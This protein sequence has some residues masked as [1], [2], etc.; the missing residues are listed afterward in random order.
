[1]FYKNPNYEGGKKYHQKIDEIEYLD[2]KL[3]KRLN[4]NEIHEDA[5]SQDIVN[6]MKFDEPIEVS[7]F[8]DGEIKIIDGHHRVGAAKRLGLN[9]VKVKVQAVNAK[10]DNINS[11]I[12]ESNRLKSLNNPRWRRLNKK[13]KRLLSWII[14]NGHIYDVHADGSAILYD[15]KKLGLITI[16]PNDTKGSPKYIPTAAGKSFSLMNSQYKNIDSKELNDYVNSEYAD[17]FLPERL[18]QE[19]ELKLAKQ[20]IGPAF[21]DE[22]GKLK[23]KEIWQFRPPNLNNPDNNNKE[24]FMKDALAK[25]PSWAKILQEHPDAYIIRK[26]RRGGYYNDVLVWNDNK[27]NNNPVE[28]DD[29]LD[30]MDMVLKQAHMARNSGDVEEEKYLKNIA[31]DIAQDYE[32]M[33]Q[34]EDNTPIAYRFQQYKNRVDE[35]KY[36]QAMREKEDR[37]RNKNPIP[38]G[39]M[40][41]RAAIGY[42]GSSM[43]P[44]PE[45]PYYK[46]EFNRLLD[47]MNEA[48]DSGDHVTAWKLGQQLKELD[49]EYSSDED[50]GLFGTEKA[51]NIQDQY[52]KE[53]GL[54]FY[55]DLYPRVKRDFPTYSGNGDP[56][57]DWPYIPTPEDYASGH[58]GNIGASEAYWATGRLRNDY[59]SPGHGFKRNPK[60]GFMNILIGIGLIIGIKLLCKGGR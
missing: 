39:M 54:R 27:S 5:L 58:E 52:D 44:N 42:T 20:S 10:G 48:L 53:V 7:L 21:Y 31:R 24:K 46:K 17:S 43:L 35:E 26:K 9:K 23:A 22:N 45:W 14:N 3:L 6:G 30:Q 55:R 1:M 56:H 51:K 59:K 38:L 36:E 19:D 4:M 41:G 60:R 16:D 29:L 40:L 25:H 8:A 2:P 12:E 11:M 32:N 33:F 28:P 49:M 13:Q 18:D 37:K 47:R 15:L 34:D 57:V 50:M